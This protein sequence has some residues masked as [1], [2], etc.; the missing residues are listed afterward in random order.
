MLNICQLFEELLSTKEDISTTVI[1][2][3][4]SRKFTE[5]SKKFKIENAMKNTILKSLKDF[6]NG[7]ES[8]TVSLYLLKDEN[9]FGIY[10]NDF[11]GM[12]FIDYYWEQFCDSDCFKLVITK[13][14]G[15][16]KSLIVIKE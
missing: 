16:Q 10:K 2:V 3:K 13:P 1:S 12:C 4:D 5:L 9:I 7:F 11:Y 8:S 15:I 14:S 6:I